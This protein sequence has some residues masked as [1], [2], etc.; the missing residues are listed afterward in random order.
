MR[1]EK[2][3]ENTIRVLLENDDLE[4][5]GITG[6]DLLSNHKKIERFF[7]SILEE[8]DQDHVFAN[9]DAV[10]FQVLPNEQGLE[11]LI[12]KNLSNLDLNKAQSEMVQGK[13][14]ITEYI[15]DQ[16]LK[17]DTASS[18]DD[19]EDD[20][21]ESYLN[22]VDNPTKQVVLGFDTFEDWIALAQQL[23]IESGVSNLFVYKH[24][25]YAQLVFF[26]ENTTE[27]FV[28]DDLAVAN[29]FGHKTNYTADFLSEYGQRVMENS[30]LELTRYYF[31]D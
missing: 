11:L 9:N 23:H 27:T 10:T 13:D 30:A 25:Y 7:Y 29:E 20:E 22:Q 2:I 3:D 24:Q 18:E 15:K 8:V 31:K 17:R 6:L 1:M 12:S 26:L 4:E 5:R 14:G 16:L 21:I 28:Q 19:E